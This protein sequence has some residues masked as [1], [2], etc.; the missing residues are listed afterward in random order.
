[1]T[2]KSSRKKLL[3]LT[4]ILTGIL[5][6][7]FFAFH[8][9]INYNARHIIT[10]MVESRSNGRLKMKLEKFRFSWFSRKVELTNAVIYTA[11]SV[12]AVTA[13]RFQVQ[14]IKL[15]VQKIWPIIFDK[16]LLI[17]SLNL[18]QP[19]ITVTRLKHLPAD[20]AS[21]KEVSIPEELGKIYTSIQ[22]ALQALKVNRFQI[23]NAKFTLLNKIR[24]DQLPLSISNIHFH[25]DNLSVDTGTLKGNEKLFFSDNVVLNARNQDI[26]F[27]DG[28]HRLAFRHF[29]INLKQQLVEFDSCTMVTEQKDRGNSRFRVFF[30]TLRLANIDFDTLY[31]SEV[32]KAD[33]VYCL[34]PRFDLNVEGNSRRK[35]GEKRTS[36]KLE[37]IV[38][39]LTGDLLLDHVIVKNADFHIK[40]NIDQRP[41]SFE[42]TKNNFE[43]QGLKVSQHAP[44]PLTVKSVALA[45]RNYE[46]FIRDSTYKLKFDS[47]VIREDRVYLDRFEFQKQIGGK[48]TNSFSIPRFEL[49]GLSWDDLVFNQQ[50]KA[51]EATLYHPSINYSAAINVSTKGKG[52]KSIFSTLAE[53]GE[54]IQLEKMNILDGQIDIS[55]KNNTSIQL[56]EAT[57][58]I[59]TKTLFLAKKARAI[60]HAVDY[61]AFSTGRIKSGKLEIQLDD[62]KYTGNMNGFLLARKARVT[63]KESRMDI[64]AENAAVDD[65]LTDEETGDIAATGIRWD[66]ADVWLL[67]APPGNSPTKQPAIE[68][69]DLSGA[70]TRV[71]ISTGSKTIRSFINELKLEELVS[72]DGRP[73]YLKNPVIRGDYAELKDSITHFS[74]KKFSI[75][76]KR[77]S[78]LNDVTY[79]HTRQQNSTRLRIPSVS[80]IP[81]IN[82][83]LNGRYMMDQLVLNKPVL[84]ADLSDEGNK[85][86]LPPTHIGHLLV[87][88]PEIRFSLA[89]R[90]GSIHIDWHG[91][92]ENDNKVEIRQ[93]DVRQHQPELRLESM[94]LNLDHFR[95]QSPKGKHYDAGAGNIETV[96]NNLVYHPA[97]DEPADWTATVS[98]F[99]ARQF[100]IDSMGKKNGILHVETAAIH[101]MEINSDI[102]TDPY[103]LVAGNTRFRLERFTGQYRD[104]VK[105]FNWK[106]AGYS[107]LTHMITLD[108]FAYRH[109]LDVDSFISRQQYQKDYIAVGCG[110]ME[111]GPVNRKRFLE[112]SIFQIGKIKIEQAW[113]TD[114][115]DK[116][117]PFAAGNIRLLPVN[118]VRHIPFKISA[119]T[120]QVNPGSVDYTE[121]N[122][123]TQAAGTIPIRRM[124]ITLLNVKNHDIRKHDSLTIRATGYV[125]DS[126]WVQLR[127]KE[128]YTDSLGGFKMTL[129]AK[130]GN[131][132]V[133]NPVLIPLVS[134]KLISGEVD[135][136][137]LRATGREY[138]TIG[139]MQM[140]YRNL[141]FRYLKD[142]KDEK[143]RFFTRLKN[144]IANTFVIRKNNSSRTGHVFALRARDR[145]AINYLLR[146]TLSGVS[147]SAGV[148]KNKKLYRRYLH[149]LEKKGLPPPW[150]E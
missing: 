65:I 82:E 98:Q 106:H 38:Q 21:K 88:Q 133:L 58:T 80:V 13:Y 47:I 143:Q 89:G 36:P 107:Q 67:V 54:L 14:H 1:M 64:S 50:L 8:T 145:S 97:D 91:A 57:M 11:D 84:T 122:D 127:L 142:G 104:A 59:R 45:I 71:L 26:V 52:K 61:L 123:K 87:T 33:T 90:N 135:T 12:N 108:T 27:P 31:R 128:S 19:E 116:R 75:E 137:H 69:K 40:T 115:K 114:Y 79:E 93:L 130:P 136:L 94:E 28:R 32:I 43:L 55:L 56:K 5:L 150:Y 138:M 73:L 144:Y 99:T 24:P 9:W 111:I 53:I 129:R 42:F 126:I 10:E 141:K 48:I 16:K 7:L 34:N 60:E 78:V 118:M 146:I 92:I 149:E 18:E 25:I 124:D 39:Q 22:D 103:R 72:E 77:L 51:K 68:L 74:V 120:I 100:I 110:P 44:R 105:Q 125:M 23:D 4:G 70:N 62:V 20:T 30:D 86:F 131:L 140:N 148:T 96:I 6:L 49:S 81:D 119:D 2:T 15:S 112:D 121:F 101:N 66:K 37:E 35:T 147:S 3:K 95:Y 29:R 63:D 132:A 85:A 117:L 102:L 113:F 17:D 76:D 109:S 139:E 41:A 46:N 83:M 134:A